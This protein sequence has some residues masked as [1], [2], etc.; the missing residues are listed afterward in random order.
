MRVDEVIAKLVKE[1]GVSYVN[2]D[3][4]HEGI[5]ANDIGLYFNSSA[6]ELID[7]L[8]NTPLQHI[9]YT[10]CSLFG[11]HVALSKQMILD[12]NTFL[13]DP[14]D[15]IEEMMTGE[16]NCYF[17]KKFN[18]SKEKMECIDELCTHLKEIYPVNRIKNNIRLIADEL[19]TNVLYNGPSS[20]EENPEI[21]PIARKQEMNIGEKYGL[22]FSFIKDD[23]VFIGA[24]D[25]FGSLPIERTLK[26]LRK[27]FEQ[28]IGDSLNTGI[29]GAGVGI[30]LSFDLSSSMT[31][32]VDKW[33]MTTVM[34]SLPTKRDKTVENLPKSIH[35]IN[36]TKPKEE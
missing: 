12:Q 25:Q 14:L 6:P 32:I 34:F 22:I 10:G 17:S 33:N 16:L 5:S 27:T 31:F 35:L 29:G 20:S 11:E 1:D 4:T 13:V 24:R 23:Q 28:G 36:C 21:V 18:S 2:L 8:I 7:L 3:E 15:G 30:R 19:I 9:V 26:K